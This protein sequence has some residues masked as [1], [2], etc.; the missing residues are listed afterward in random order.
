MPFQTL[1]PE[2]V[3][4]IL[5]WALDFT[6]LL[7]MI[8]TCKLAYEVFK[9][10]SDIIF[11]AVFERT[12]ICILE[13]FSTLRKVPESRKI[14]QEFIRKQSRPTSKTA[15]LCKPLLGILPDLE[16]IQRR[17]LLE[18]TVVMCRQ[19]AEKE[20]L[21]Q[22]LQPLDYDNI[23]QGTVDDRTTLWKTDSEVYMGILRQIE[24]HR[25]NPDRYNIW[26]NCQNEI[27]VGCD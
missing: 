17:I 14:R 5:H 27:L 13:T 25:I 8:K 12:C 10:S 18:S 21:S 2:L 19:L 3:A 26:L 22:I 1:P 15:N 9:S 24:Y 4:G 23:Y 16:I 11:H 20:G 7:S 6:S